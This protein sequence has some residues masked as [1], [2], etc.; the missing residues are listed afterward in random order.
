MGRIWK[1][2][3]AKNRLSEL[4]DEAERCGPQVV[5]RRGKETAVVM[6]FEDFQR[7]SRPA[8]SLVQFLQRSPLYEAGLDLKRSQE[9]ARDVEL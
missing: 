2:Q 7:L 1:L 3:D 8:E 5:T 4:V 6:S 9:L